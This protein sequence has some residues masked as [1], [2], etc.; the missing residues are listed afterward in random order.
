MT[1]D[2]RVAFLGCPTAP[3]AAWDETNLCRL[4]ALGFNTIQLHIA[5]GARPGDEPL[6][7]EDVVSLPAGHA[8]AFDPLPIP[9]D[10]DPTPGRAVAR[11][12]ALEAR[13][14]LCRSLGLRTIFHFGAPYNA[15][16]S[17]W[18][19]LDAGLKLCLQDGQT[20][21]YYVALLEA[22]HA[23]FPGVDDLLVYTYDQDAWLCN[24]F[25]T[26]E[27]CFGVPLHERVVPFVDL[28]T[29][30]WR[31]LNPAG[32]VWWSPW[33]L[34]AGQVL[35][36]VE[37]LEPA[38]LG[39]DL[40]PNIAETMAA[41]PV[42]RW[43]KNVAALAAGRG[44]PVMVESFL[45]AA[46]EEVEPFQHLAHPLVTRRQIM[47]LAAV[48][49]VCGIKEYY[50]LR[51]DVEDPNLR[52]AGLTFTQPQLSEDD[53]LAALAAPYG[54]AAAGVAEFWR[55][56]SAAQ[57]LFPYDTSWFAREKGKT[58]LNHSLNAAFLRGE[59]C[60]TPAWRS[61]RA[62]IF[63]KTDSAQPHPW[64]LEDVQLRCQLAADRM[65]AALALGESL[66]ALIP[67]A[68]AQTFTA[69]LAELALFH[70]QIMS[71]VYHLRETNLAT[72]LRQAAESGHGYPPRLVAELDALLAADAANQAND[73]LT[74]MGSQ[75]VWDP[76]HQLTQPGPFATRYFRYNFTVDT[77]VRVEKAELLVANSEFILRAWVNGQSFGIEQPYAWP[78]R[79]D[80]TAYLHAGDNRLALAVPKAGSESPRP[81]LIVRLRIRYADGAEQ[82]IDSGADWQVTDTTAPGWEQPGLAPTGA[83]R[84]VEI[85]GPFGAAPWGIKGFGD[86]GAAAGE[87]LALFRVDV[88]S[89]LTR[90]FQPAP[91]AAT[92][93]AFSLTSR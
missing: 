63:M 86:G 31:R 36:C 65:A 88:D 70:R 20:P 32:R 42:D 77:A 29:S 12:S 13:L 24:E 79:V 73:G 46:S 91:D 62:L 1:L 69:G 17:S 45:G 10:S 75:W 56:C 3:D 74:L 83:W 40:H 71:Y 64:M 28:L 59:M 27:H 51:P 57:E 89:F 72:L 53:A 14:A 58:D 26:C 85:L 25:G 82:T 93:G 7:L 22:F 4:M 44:I 80:V 47:A 87:A 41:H 16:Y 19:G 61:S 67:T 9:L 6:N 55:L 49:G 50:G 37:M 38:G 78:F 54:P 30:T 66:R 76:A 52:M 84:S 15:I 43:L 90:Y 21:A 11:A 92:H 39:L 8:A 68:L 34:S 18:Q 2:Y 81:G 23:R 35:R 48:P 60:S 33:E 5:W